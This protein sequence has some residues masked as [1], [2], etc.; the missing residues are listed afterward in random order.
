M[1]AIMSMR[2][3]ALDLWRPSPP[4]DL[5]HRQSPHLSLFRS[6]VDAN[7]VGMIGKLISPKAVA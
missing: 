1:S 5:E 6:G 3:Q 7:P 4:I 2:C